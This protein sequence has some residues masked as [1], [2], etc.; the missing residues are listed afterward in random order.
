[1]VGMAGTKGVKLPRWAARPWIVVPAAVVGILA[2]VW[3][4]IAV[5]GAVAGTARYLQCLGKETL[6]CGKLAPV[7]SQTTTLAIIL[8]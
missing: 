5:G 3:A 2:M 8:G 7:P 6:L 4:S 1:M